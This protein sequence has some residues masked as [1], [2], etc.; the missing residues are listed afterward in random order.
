MGLMWCMGKSPRLVWDRFR[1]R[2]LGTRKGDRGPECSGRNPWGEL[3]SVGEWPNGRM[4]K[5][6]AARKLITVNPPTSA[7]GQ[8]R[9]RKGKGRDAPVSVSASASV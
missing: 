4:G 7:G 1:F 5:R 9:E 6:G 3:M 8:G 2:K